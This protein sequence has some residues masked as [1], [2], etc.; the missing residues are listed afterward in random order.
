MK[1]IEEKSLYDYLYKGYLCHNNLTFFEGER[2][3]SR[4]NAKEFLAK[5]RETDLTVEEAIEQ[6]EKNITDY[7]KGIV[8]KYKKPVLLSGAGYD[9]N[10]IRK[11]YEKNFGPLITI[12]HSFYGT[13]YDEYKL[14]KE[15]EKLT[16]INYVVR[17][18]DDVLSGLSSYI[19]LT[20]RPISGLPTIGIFKAQKFAKDIGAD[21]ILSGVE[22]AIWFS[23]T[24]DCIDMKMKSAGDFM[25]LK[26]T[27]FLIE[28]FKNRIETEDVELNFKSKIKKHIF[29]QFL[30]Y[31]SPKVICDFETAGKVNNLDQAFPYLDPKNIDLVL[32]L[33]DEVIHFDN[34]P[35]SLIVKLIE[36]V[37]GKPFNP[38]LGM[39]SPQRELIRMI[40][41]DSII[42]L[43]KES[44][45]T[46]DGFVDKDK[47]LT[48]FKDYCEQKELGN[49]FFIWKFITAEI[50]YR[51]YFYGIKKD[52]YPRYT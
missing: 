31:K 20:G 10:L 34:Q 43:I 45:L 9:S 11:I 19:S 13:P 15:K 2:R 30:I 17:S 7:L 51:I 50:W 6:I 35:K 44:Y 33:K 14:L 36:K 21:V 46:K 32:S 41:R 38:G 16:E 4:Y 12:T 39:M 37:G 25:E 8:E 52:L 22:D 24:L 48:M 47:L 40:Y 26:K 28:N 49:S 3:E 29:E 23:S 27:D 5:E 1:K 18:Y 42:E